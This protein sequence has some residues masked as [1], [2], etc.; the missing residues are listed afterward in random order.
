MSDQNNSNKSLTTDPEYRDA[1]AQEF[2]SHIELQKHWDRL[3]VIRTLQKDSG[4]CEML[5]V[6]DEAV[7]LAFGRV[8]ADQQAVEEKHFEAM[9]AITEWTKGHTS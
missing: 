4:L 9:N 3:N 1:I 8:H 2:K 6:T 7:Y 5:G